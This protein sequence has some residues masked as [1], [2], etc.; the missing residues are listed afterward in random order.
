MY[1]FYP[2]PWIYTYLLYVHYCK[3]KF[4]VVVGVQ[5][6]KYNLTGSIL[7]CRIVLP[8]VLMGGRKIWQGRTNQQNTGFIDEMRMTIACNVWCSPGTHIPLQCSTVWI[9]ENRMSG[10]R[11]IMSPV[12][13]SD[14]VQYIWG[15]WGA[16]VVLQVRV[17]F[18]L[19]ACGK[20]L[21]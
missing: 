12:R 6:N 9:S 11:I 8:T 14:R 7:R 4:R 17:Q 20:N 3:G 13:V 10:C 2:Q 5:I 16:C 19:I 18:S 15:W 21:S 1:P